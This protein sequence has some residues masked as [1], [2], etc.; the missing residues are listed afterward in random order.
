MSRI[1]DTFFNAKERQLFET[2]SKACPDKIS[3][4][5]IPNLYFPLF[6]III[7]II[8]YSI[9]G[10]AKNEAITYLRIILN[11]S[12]PLIALNQVS[13]SG[14]SVFKFDKNREKQL[15]IV[16]TEDLRT[17]LNYYAQLFVVFPSAAFYIFQVIGNVKLG[18]W[19]IVVNLICSLLLIWLALLI[20]S[21][22]YLLRTDIID[23]AYNMNT[24]VKRETEE[25]HGHGW[26]A[27]NE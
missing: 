19:F 5:K 7:A 27:N 23:D 14:L 16:E 17:K 3:I 1:Q 24:L 8:G 21:K 22:L 26:E 11:G 10:E 20:G 12:L 6:A 15:N 18:A 25:N 13:G 9:F 4:W 2:L